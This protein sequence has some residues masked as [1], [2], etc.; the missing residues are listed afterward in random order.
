MQAGANDL[1][2][3]GLASSTFAHGALVHGASEI[4]RKTGT[5]GDLVWIFRT[6]MAEIEKAPTGGASELIGPD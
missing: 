1:F 4:I 2:E 6:V 5:H 3:H